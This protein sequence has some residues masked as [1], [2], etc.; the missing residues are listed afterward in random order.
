MS[1]LKD[2]FVDALVKDPARGTR[3]AC[4][5][6]EELEQE[7][8]NRGLMLSFNKASAKPVVPAVPSMPGMGTCVQKLRVGITQDGVPDDQPDMWRIEDITADHV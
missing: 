7:A 3:D 4:L 5:V 6:T 2:K 8:S 1:D